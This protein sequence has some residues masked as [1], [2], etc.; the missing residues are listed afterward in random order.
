M[1][2]FSQKQGGKEVGQAS[3]YAKPH[4]NPVKSGR[5]V[6]AGEKLVVTRVNGSQP[7]TAGGVDIKNNG[8]DG[9]NRFT[10]NDVNMSVGN[11]S[12]DPYKAPKTSGVQTRGNGCAT[13][14]TIARGPMA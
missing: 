6:P 4:N 1:A 8:Y 3:V 5:P 14:G 11:I 2:K 9:G 10:A 12:R 13:K 7:S